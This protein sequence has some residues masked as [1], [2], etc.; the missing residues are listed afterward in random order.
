MIATAVNSSINVL[1]PRCKILSEVSTIKQIPSKF[2]EV[3]K[4]CEDLLLFFSSI[5]CDCLLLKAVKNTEDHYLEKAFC[6]SNVFHLQG[7]VKE[8]ETRV[9][10]TNVIRISPFFNS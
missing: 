1:P 4:M 6:H 8:K 2:E 9:T 3:V 5:C 10:T 7:F